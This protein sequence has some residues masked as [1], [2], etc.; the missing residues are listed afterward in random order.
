ME[1]CQELS[2]RKKSIFGKPRIK[3]QL[4]SL[5]TKYDSW[6]L[7]LDTMDVFVENR[8]AVSRKMLVQVFINDV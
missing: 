3:G 8:E 5:F 1:S 7:G 2:S 6:G 4:G